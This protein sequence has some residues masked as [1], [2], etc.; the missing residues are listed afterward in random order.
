MPTARLPTWLREAGPLHDKGLPLNWTSNRN[1]CD[2]V[3]P[4]RIPGWGRTH[5]S[6]LRVARNIQQEG[7]IMSASVKY[8]IPLGALLTVFLVPAVIPEARAARHHSSISVGTALQNHAYHYPHWRNSRTFRP[9]V[10]T[11]LHHLP[12]RH[13]RPWNR[14]LRHYPGSGYS[15]YVGVNIPFGF[16]VSTLPRSYTTGVVN[17]TPCCFTN[18][19]YYRDV[20]RGYMVV[21]TPE[22]QPPQQPQRT[23]PASDLVVEVNRTHM[24]SG[25]GREHPVTGQAYYGQ[26]LTIVGEAPEWYYVQHPH[27]HYGWIPKRDTRP[28]GD[29][30]DGN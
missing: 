9:R 28:T 2:N 14:Y 11:R 16:R 18:G 3:V 30:S 17:H 24:R 1:I 20:E 27:G 10:H 7:C 25:P 23:Y 4:V 29:T 15:A 8:L 19:A 26:P 21:E 22:P 6:E 5:P 12:S 13:V